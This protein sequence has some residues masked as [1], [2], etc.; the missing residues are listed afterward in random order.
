MRQRLQTEIWFDRSCQEFTTTTAY[1]NRLLV[2]MAS[3][4]L[5]AIPLVG[6]MRLS[7]A[8]IYKQIVPR[9]APEREPRCFFVQFMQR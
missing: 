6:P 5:K 1:P 7:R 3:L 8:E 4:L 9:K 2:I